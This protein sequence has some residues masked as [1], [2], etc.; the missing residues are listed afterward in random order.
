MTNTPSSTLMGLRIHAIVFAAVIPIEFIVNYFTGPPWWAVW[1]LLGWGIG[2][3]SH[4]Y[5]TRGKTA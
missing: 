3:L 5:F 2:L 1:V 4:W